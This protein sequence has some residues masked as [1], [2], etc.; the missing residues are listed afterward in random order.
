MLQGNMTT[1]MAAPVPNTGYSNVHRD[2]V[3]PHSRV[4]TPLLPHGHRQQPQQPLRRHLYN[5]NNN[6]GNPK[7]DLRTA[8][9]NLTAQNTKG[10]HSQILVN[11]PG[12]YVLPFGPDILRPVDT[13]ERT[14][15]N[16]QSRRFNKEQMAS[17][18]RDLA[19][20]SE[21]LWFRGPSVVLSTRV[22]NLGNEPLEMP[23]NRWFGKNKKPKLEFE[24]IEE[25]VDE[26]EASADRNTELANTEAPELET[27]DDDED[28][29][30]IMN[31]FNS[32]LTPSA[33]FLSFK[34]ASRAS[35]QTES[36]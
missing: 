31:P 20:A 4:N 25:Q 2:Y 21:I 3:G 5:K 23:L 12:A 33:K 1:P 16:N 32:C 7:V 18:K 9:N 34:I 36:L 14:D 8:I 19:M 30:Q 24:E 28:N 6:N 15:V 10:A 35:L 17:R 11:A 27:E 29:E 26:Q 13:V 22:L